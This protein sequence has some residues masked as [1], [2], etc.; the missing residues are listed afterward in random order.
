MDYSSIEIGAVTKHATMIT[1]TA[2]TTDLCVPCGPASS[3]Q[4]VSSKFDDADWCLASCSS[5]KTMEGRGKEE[6]LMVHH[7]TDCSFNKVCID[8]GAGESVCPVDAFPSYGLK[9]L[10][11]TGATYTAAGGQS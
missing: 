4:D 2:A 7:L 6:R 9:K 1:S 10:A 11:K 8:S 3:S 5:W